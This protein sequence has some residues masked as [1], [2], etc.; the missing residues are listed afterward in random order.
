MNWNCSLLLVIVVV[1][2]IIVCLYNI[3]FNTTL[4]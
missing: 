1:V 3:I 2:I 4:L